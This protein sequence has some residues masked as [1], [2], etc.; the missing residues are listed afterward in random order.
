M[1]GLHILDH[2][3]PDQHMLTVGYSVC[4]L[5]TDDDEDDRPRRTG[6]WEFVTIHGT[7]R[8]DQPRPTLG[9][10]S[11]DA[12]LDGVDGELRSLVTSAPMDRS[13]SVVQE[14]VTWPDAD[15]RLHVIRMNRPDPLFQSG[16]MR[17]DSDIRWPLPHLDRPL[18]VITGSREGAGWRDLAPAHDVLDHCQ[19]TS[20]AKA[21]A[22]ALRST[23][24]SR[25]RWGGV[26]ITRG[27]GAANERGDWRDTFSAPDVLDATAEIQAGGLVVLSGLGHEK[28]VTALDRLADYC[29]PTPSALAGTLHRLA[30]YR[31]L[32]EVEPVDG[33]RRSVYD[34]GRE[35]RQ[36]FDNAW[37][38]L[39]PQSRQLQRRPPWGSGSSRLDRAREHIRGVLD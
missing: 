7:L 13:R 18:R 39:R 15:L 34:L 19:A 9:L 10:D 20:S 35:V 2:L 21:L 28:D 31:E 29:W 12:I 38:R 37:A 14:F 30:R 36:E 16:R 17:E 23:S 6:S 25:D 1:A 5:R 3:I 32:A 24:H 26:V 33:L 4:G 22:A 8:S 27:G 11:F